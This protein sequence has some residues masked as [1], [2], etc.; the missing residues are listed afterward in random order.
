MAAIRR[1][2]DTVIRQIAADALADF[3]LQCSD[4][5][6]SPNDRYE[7]LLPR[8]HRLAM[9]SNTASYRLLFTLTV[10]MQAGQEHL[11]HGVRRHSSHAQCK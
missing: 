11:Q 4:R 10:Y 1:E 2:P 6:P 7:H 3:A 8:V 9:P 5:K